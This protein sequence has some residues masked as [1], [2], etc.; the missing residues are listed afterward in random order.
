MDQFVVSSEV[1]F[2][3]FVFLLFSVDHDVVHVDRCVS[4]GYSQP[5][6]SIHHH[7]ECCG[8]VGKSKEHHGWFKQPFWGKEGCLPFIPGFDS[9]VVVSPMDVD[10]GE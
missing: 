7:L 6:N 8:G 1:L 10:L 9:D 2:F 5:E 4:H 3:C